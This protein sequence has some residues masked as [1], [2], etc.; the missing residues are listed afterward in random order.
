VYRK[1][2]ARSVDRWMSKGLCE[3]EDGKGVSEAKVEGWVISKWVEGWM[4]DS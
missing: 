4:L 2:V 1:M 3:T